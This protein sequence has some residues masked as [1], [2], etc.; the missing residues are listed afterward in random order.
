[1][2]ESAYRTL[3]DVRKGPTCPGT[4]VL[5]GCGIGQPPRR[6]F[7]DLTLDAGVYF[8]QIDGHALEEGPWFLDVHVVDP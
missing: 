3:L 6:S 2:D 5:Q 7:L 8:I 4:E 1:M